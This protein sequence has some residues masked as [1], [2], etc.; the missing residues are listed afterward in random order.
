MSPLKI[1]LKDDIW[2][3]LQSFHYLWLLNSATN[4][5]LFTDVFLKF[6]C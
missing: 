4:C 3:Y 2:D 6:K 1:S 5:Y